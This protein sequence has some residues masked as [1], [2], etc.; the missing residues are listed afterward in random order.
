MQ[1]AVA[2]RYVDGDSLVRR[3]VVHV[4][5]TRTTQVDERDV[6]VHTADARRS[7]AQAIA[8]GFGVAGNWIVG[9]IV[10][11]LCTKDC[12]LVSTI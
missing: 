9:E 5:T 7:V 6:E 8:F 10:W 4:N 1:Q 12:V 2:V 11:K 3:N